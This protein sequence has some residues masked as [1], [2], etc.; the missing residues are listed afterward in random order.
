MIKELSS[1]HKL[2]FFSP[3]SLQP[4]S[5]NLGYKTITYKRS[6]S[7][8]LKYHILEK[9]SLCHELSFFQTSVVETLVKINLEF[10][11]LI[12]YE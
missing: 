2:C 8:R 6:N 4:D 1:C 12:L 9:V 10:L 11:K 7:L 3:T 5:I